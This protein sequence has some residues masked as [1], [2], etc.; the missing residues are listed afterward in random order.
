M[1]KQI[2]LFALV[3][4]SVSA[5]LE[6]TNCGS[7][8]QVVAFRLRGCDATPCT[9]RRG[10]EYYGEMDVIAAVPTNVLP[11]VIQAILGFPLPPVTIF[12]GNACDD[13]TVGSCPTHVGQAITARLYMDIP[14][15]LPAISTNVRAT[16][17]DA[18]NQVQVCVQIPVSL[19]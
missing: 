14:T 4:V 12:D 7:A 16:V 11:F 13:L 17:R 5:N 8:S 2:V 1:F 15:T 19:I 18:L 6:F 3:T 9:F 10:G